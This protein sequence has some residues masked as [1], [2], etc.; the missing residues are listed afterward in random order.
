MNAPTAEVATWISRDSTV[1]VLTGA[2]IST[3]SGIPDFREPQGLWSR[4]P[5]K[6]RLFTIQNYLADPDVRAEAWRERLAHPAWRAH[7]GPGH[8][9]LV[10]LER[11]GKLRAI[12]TQNIDGLHQAAGSVRVT[13]LHGSIRRVRCADEGTVVDRWE[14]DGVTPPHCPACGGLLRPDVTWF[15][16]YLPEGAVEAAWEAA[17]RCDLFLSVGTSNL[18]E[19]AASL[20]WIAHRRGV[21]VIV[22]NTTDEG[23]RHG[24]GIHHLLGKAGEVL[25]EVLGGSRRQRR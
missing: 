4:G 18:V 23:Q 12:A 19:P 21:P 14:D 1:A 16:E 8:E 9:A 15:G 5:G 10:E 20:P 11:R 24:T 25:P 7:P 22:V 2:G 3:D 6:Q 17:E 13:E